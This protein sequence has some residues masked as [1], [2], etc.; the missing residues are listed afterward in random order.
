MNAPLILHDL[1][2][3]IWLDGISR[4]L[5]RSGRSIAIVLALYRALTGLVAGIQGL[6][7][8]AFASAPAALTLVALMAGLAPLRRALRVDPVTTLDFE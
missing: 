7:L 8:A 1:G 5:P 3:S 2:Q 6:D 4:N